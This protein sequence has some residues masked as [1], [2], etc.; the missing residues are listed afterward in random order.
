MDAKKSFL[1]NTE[2]YEVLRDYP[3]EVRLEVYE[4]IIRYCASGTLSEMKPLAKMAFAFIRRGIDYNEAKYQ[5]TVEARRE[6]GRKSATAR[7]RQK[8][9]KT[10]DVEFAKHQATKSTNV[11]FVEQ[12]QQKT[13]KS[14]DNVNVYDNDNIIVVDEDHAHARESLDDYQQRLSENA[15]FWENAAMSRHVD[16]DTLKAMLPRFVADSKAR[17]KTDATYSDFKNHFLSWFNCQDKPQKKTRNDTNDRYSKRRGAD[18]AA[19][20]PDDYTGAL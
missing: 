19:R 8:I 20:S 6:A 15:M 1:F 17:D 14:T 2:W 13:A 12:N 3:A 4:A 11:E 5:Q 18:S 7:T 10:T 9:A 16:I